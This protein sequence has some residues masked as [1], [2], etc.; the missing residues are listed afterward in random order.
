MHSYTMVT[1]LGLT[2]T[3]CTS[4]QR[5]HCWNI[6]LKELVDKEEGLTYIFDKEIKWHC[7][8]NIQDTGL[9]WQWG[10][11]VYRDQ[12]GREDLGKMD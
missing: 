11:I 2:V 3:K 4:L 7:S 8:Q 5:T 6:K 10:I 1:L 9:Y 12:N